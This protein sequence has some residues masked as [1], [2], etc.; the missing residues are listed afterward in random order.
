M[1]DVIGYFGPWL[2]FVIIIIYNIWLPLKYNLIYVL[3]ILINMISNNIIKQYIQ[4]PRPNNEKH[5]F[6]FEKLKYKNNNSQIYGMPSGHSQMIWFSVAFSLFVLENIYLF[7]FALCM[8]FNTMRQR[9]KYRNHTK[10]QIFAG[11][12]FG[13]MIGYLSYKI[14]LNI[15]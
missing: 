8:A 9:Y 10:G 15:K 13:F 14:S 2:L 7:L 12:I 5:L 4:E 1:Y 6:Y 3:F 11:S